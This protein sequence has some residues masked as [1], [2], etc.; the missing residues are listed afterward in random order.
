V[1][2][3][4]PR[5][6]AQLSCISLFLIYNSASIAQI[7]TAPHTRANVPNHALADLLKDLRPKISLEQ[8]ARILRAKIK[9]D[10]RQLQIVNNDLMQRTLIESRKNP[11]AISS[12]EIRA[13]LG[14][15]QKRASRL[16][17]NLRLPEVKKAKEEFNFEMSNGLLVL[18]ETVMRFVENPIFQR[19]G[20]LDAEQSVS[21]SEDLSKILRLTELLRKMVKEDFLPGQTAQQN[22]KQ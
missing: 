19:P 16:Q 11:Q 18:D 1:R 15:M 2:H 9:D 8:E 6:C 3:I 13:S 7:R 4:T 21:A 20:I 22:A 14:E 10:F 5:L 17:T 12:K